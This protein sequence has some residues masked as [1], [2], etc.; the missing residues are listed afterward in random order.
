MAPDVICGT[1]GA[2]TAG[3]DATGCVSCG[4]PLVVLAPLVVDC[5][6]CRASNHRDQT[7]NC[8]RC[9][10]PLPALPG[11]EPGPRPPSVPRTLP[12]GY[13]WRVRLWHNVVACIGA[14]FTIIFFWSI[15]FPIIGIPMWYFGD[16]KAR[17][18]LHALEH[19][20]PTRGSLTRV[21]ID[22]SQKSN[23]KSPW[24]LEYRFDHHDGTQ[25]DA[26]L[27]VWDPS[28]AGRRKGDALWVVYGEMKDGYL[29]SAI[30]PPLR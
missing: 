26:F 18:W 8:L 1:C 10:G 25:H 3:G 28:H 21:S 4:A 23:G 20:R 30:W 9:G 12:E 16:R 7:A 24:R 19:G 27:E 22:Y 2:Q 5:G 6:W 11:G 17:R 29:A 13:R 14:A 15:I